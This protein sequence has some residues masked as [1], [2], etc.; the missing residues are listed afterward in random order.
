MS[1]ERHRVLGLPQLPPW[2]F[3]GAMRCLCFRD[4]RNHQP[5]DYTVNGNGEGDLANHISQA[6]R[7]P[8]RVPAGEMR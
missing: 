4:Q 7:D 8:A 2:I 5:L 1:W 3:R 6:S